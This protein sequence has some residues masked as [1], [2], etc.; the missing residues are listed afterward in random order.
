MEKLFN[1]LQVKTHSSAHCELK[2]KNC[3]EVKNSA[4]AHLSRNSFA[5]PAESSSQAQPSTA[6]ECCAAVSRWREKQLVAVAESRVDWNLISHLYLAATRATVSALNSPKAPCRRRLPHD[7][8][9]D[10]RPQ[11]SHRD[12]RRRLV[13]IQ[14]S[15]I[16]H[17]CSSRDWAPKD[18]RRWLALRYVSSAV[19]R[20]PR[21]VDVL[22][23]SL[24]LICAPEWLDRRGE[25]W[26]CQ[27][28][29]F[30]EFASSPLEILHET[31]VRC[32]ARLPEIRSI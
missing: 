28:F 12:R 5:A 10:A 4:R 30:D 19:S 2:M 6:L 15:A 26:I 11:V 18:H 29:F 17:A 7:D 21:S 23:V 32:T 25:I 24:F 1:S 13:V 14:V 8:R 20:S 31:F 27:E 3:Q 22:R 16:C 9:H